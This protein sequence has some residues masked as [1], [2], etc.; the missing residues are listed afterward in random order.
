MRPKG[1]GVK[2]KH[3][4]CRSAYRAKR[5]V[6]KGCSDKVNLPLLLLFLVGVICFIIG[7]PI[8]IERGA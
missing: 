8:L 5:P 1:L 7:G 2:G 6:S 3:D 4:P